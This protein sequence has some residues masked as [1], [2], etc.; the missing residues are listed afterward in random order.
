MLKEVFKR[1]D[2]KKETLIKH[3]TDRK[4]TL[5][6]EKTWFCTLLKICPE[7]SGHEGVIKV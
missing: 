4:T 3:E 5:K 7:I 1:A 6:I 2:L